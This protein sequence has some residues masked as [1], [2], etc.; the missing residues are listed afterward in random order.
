MNEELS[1]DLKKID[2]I[3][4]KIETLLNQAGIRVYATLA[5]SEQGYLQ[6][7]LHKAGPYYRMHNPGTWPIQARL[8]ASGKWEALK[9]F[10]EELKKR[11]E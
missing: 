3:G 5:K 7:I 8:A 10:Q 2:G 9:A 11:K 1:D 4:P 6:E